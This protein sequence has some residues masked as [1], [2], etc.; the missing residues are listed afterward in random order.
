MREVTEPPEE[1][2]YKA[3]V[4]SVKDRLLK[5]RS[6]NPEPTLQFSEDEMVLAEMICSQ[7]LKI[8]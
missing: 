4:P 1:T 2:I 6:D 3:T 5:R 7:V 8:S